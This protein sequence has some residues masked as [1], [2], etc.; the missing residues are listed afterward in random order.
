MVPDGEPAGLGWTVSSRDEATRT[1]TL[2]ADRLT[3]GPTE[4]LRALLNRARLH[5]A[6]AEENRQTPG[7]AA[8]FAAEPGPSVELDQL[9]ADVAAGQ[10]DNPEFVAWAKAYAAEQR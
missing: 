8:A 7:I 6:P 1:G 4:N 2:V 9:L 10:P 5:A 3:A